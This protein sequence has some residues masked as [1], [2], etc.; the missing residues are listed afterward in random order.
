MKEF[1]VK[2]KEI[3]II[4]AIVL[5]CLIILLPIICTCKYI[6]SYA[7]DYMYGIETHKTWQETHSIIEVIKT[8][9]SKTAEI[10]ETWQGSFCAVFLMTLQPAIFGEQYYFITTI[11]L[12][13]SFIFANFY[14]MK[15]ALK[16]YLKTSNLMYVGLT[17]VLVT[18][19]IAFVPY[20]RESIFW[21]NGSIYYTFF[22][23]IMLI[24]FGTILKLFKEEK[25]SKRI[26]LLI[27]S[28]ILAI[29]VG[30]SNYSTS[31]I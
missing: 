4:L 14:F 16:D 1:F 23:S 20:P 11:I 10:Y 25:K 27:I 12:L 2:N 6:H 21:F 13:G 26:V 24:L 5:I 19:S 30:G 28:A 29:L 7:D 3:I 15:I 18:L 22:Y 9:T 17:S 8:A 31:L